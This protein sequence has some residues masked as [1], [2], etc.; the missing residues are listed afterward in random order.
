MRRIP[1]LPCAALLIAALLAGVTA[2]PASAASK[3]HEIARFDLS[4]SE[5]RAFVTQVSERNSFDAQRI[6]AL[7]GKAVPQESIIEA[8]TRPAEKTLPWWQYRAR[9]LTSER[10][11]AGL[12]F[13]ELHRERLERIAAEHGVPPEYILAILGVETLY[14]RHTGR[15]RI[16][17]ALATLAFDYPPRGE[18]FRGEL[19]QFLLMARDSE[20]DPLT[21]R[22][23]YAGAMGLPQFIPSSFRKYAIDGDDNGKRDLFEDADDVVASV[24]NYFVEHGWQRD[25]PVLAEVTAAAGIEPS[26]DESS[27][28]RA[29]AL[30]DTVGSLRARGYVFATELPES[31]PAMLVAAEAETGPAWRVGFR[32]FYAITRYNRSA[33][34]AMAVNDLA[35]A[36]AAG[37]SLPEPG[38]AN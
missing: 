21:A 19:E 5:I 4:R 27:V 30:S 11:A 23:S 34:Y 3:A 13:W 2:T 15:Y 29:L 38:R 16:L 18:F 8:M 35:Q 28:P 26:G 7:L 33:R 17:D 9:F 36:L 24:A 1:L 14:G 22:G 37:M 6:D 32:N 12:R 31:A 20:V 10:I 25:E